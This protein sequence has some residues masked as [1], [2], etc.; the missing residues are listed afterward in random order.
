ME[1]EYLEDLSKYSSGKIVKPVANIQLYSQDNNSLSRQKIVKK[2]INSKTNDK[3]LTTTNNKTKKNTWQK[4]KTPIKY[5]EKLKPSF[6]SENL[7]QRKLKIFPTNLLDKVIIAGSIKI[8]KNNTIFHSQTQKRFKYA[9]NSIQQYKEQKEKKKSL[10]FNE[11]KQNNNFRSVYT[12]LFN[13][14]DAHQRMIEKRKLYYS[15]SFGSHN[16]SAGSSLLLKNQ[17]IG[18]RRTDLYDAK[19]LI[20]HKLLPNLINREE[21]FLYD[22]DTNSNSKSNNENNSNLNFNNEEEKNSSLSNSLLFKTKEKNNQRNN[23]K[24]VNENKRKYTG[25]IYRNADI[26]S[27]YNS[28]NEKEYF[29]YRSNNSNNLENLSNKNYLHFNSVSIERKNARKKFKINSLGFNKN[30]NLKIEN[31]N[32]SDISEKLKIK[33]TNEKIEKIEKSNDQIFEIEVSNIISWRN[34]EELEISIWGKEMISFINSIKHPLKLRLLRIKNHIA[35]RS[36]KN[37][38]KYCPNLEILE[39]INAYDWSLNENKIPIYDE[40]PNLK[41]IKIKESQI[42]LDDLLICFNKSLKTLSHF[43][44]MPL[45]FFHKHKSVIAPKLYFNLKNLES[46]KIKLIYCYL[47]TIAG[48]VSKNK[49]LKELV[50]YQKESYKIISNSI[51]GISIMNK[52]ADHPKF[53]ELGNNIS[54]LD[55]LENL[56][57]FEIETQKTA[58]LCE[59]F[60]CNSCLKKLTI[61]HTS[62]LNT[63]KIINNHFNLNSIN[64]HFNPKIKN[65]EY[66]FKLSKRNWKSIVL[67]KYNFTNDTLNTLLELTKNNNNDEKL[68]KLKLFNMKNKTGKSFPDLRKMIKNAFPYLQNGKNFI[69]C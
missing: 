62:D 40:L 67:Y 34:K 30:R 42:P 2:L 58:K 41:V 59:D 25:G 55:K 24:P 31:D 66:N 47:D 10:S 20:K 54:R 36:M 26:S 63:E 23:Y 4:T 28:L 5:T 3:I 6:T 53:L 51:K 29:S 37:F 12:N 60:G 57:L 35:L 13:S 14:L 9:P 64:F 69:L 21:I 43:H 17:I 7:K 32:E 19:T 49:N 27:D 18:L 52:I 50:V 15:N 16:S 38:F 48:I 44:Y 46:L 33:K 11:N 1:I 39:I 68:E 56:Q 8:N 61:S 65:E 22:T 45:T